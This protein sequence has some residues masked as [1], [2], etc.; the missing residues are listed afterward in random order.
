VRNLLIQR[1]SALPVACSLVP[2]LPIDAAKAAY[3]LAGYGAAVTTAGAP[4]AALTRS[5]WL[6]QET[7]VQL[8][9]TNGFVAQQSATGMDPVGGVRGIP[10]RGWPV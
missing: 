9:R 5:Q 7:H 1:P 10:P 3:A 8:D 2:E 4:G 6:T